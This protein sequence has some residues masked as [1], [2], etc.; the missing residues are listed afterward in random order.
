MQDSSTPV[1]ASFLTRLR[2]LEDRVGR[3]VVMELIDLLI[4]D[5]PERIEE[6][7]VALTGNRP[8]EVCSTAHA[9]KGSASALGANALSDACL[10][11]EMLGRSGTVAGGDELLSRIRSEYEQLL[12]QCEAVKQ[13]PS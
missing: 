6:L 1:D 11:L 9:L 12:V 10:A 5:T 13:G 4:S 3:E 8:D 2:V 7:S